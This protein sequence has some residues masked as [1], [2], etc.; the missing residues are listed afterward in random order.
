M[1]RTKYYS[2]GILPGRTV[3]DWEFA[4]TKRAAFARAARHNYGGIVKRVHAGTLPVFTADIYGTEP[5]VPRWRGS[6]AEAV[7]DVEPP[8]TQYAVRLQLPGSRW[9]DVADLATATAFQNMAGAGSPAIIRRS[10][11]RQYG[12]V[13]SYTCSMAPGTG[14]WYFDEDSAILAD[15]PPKVTA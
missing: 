4:P 13:T 9:T 12:V 5:A 3:G 2:I 15:A 11:T 1:P 6:L 10:E 7:A 14:S 8:P